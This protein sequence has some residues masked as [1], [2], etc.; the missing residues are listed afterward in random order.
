MGPVA[1]LS[2]RRCVV[3]C[4]NAAL[5]RM[6]SGAA[7]RCDLIEM[8]SGFV[9]DI[10]AAGVRIAVG[11]VQQLGT[12]CAGIE[13]PCYGLVRNGL[14]QSCFEPSDF[15]VK[16]NGPAPVI[17]ISVADHPLAVAE[18]NDGIDI[19]LLVCSDERPCLAAV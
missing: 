10:I 17:D 19:D 15:I 11:H 5:A 16:V 4:A 8:M 18:A 14:A 13:E 7:I 12:V 9:V 3:S 1:M 6:S 2:R